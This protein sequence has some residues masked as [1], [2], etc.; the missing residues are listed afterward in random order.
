LDHFLK[1]VRSFSNRKGRNMS[2]ARFSYRPLSAGALLALAIVSVG[3]VWSAKA[4]QTRSQR[5]GLDGYCHV[6][7]PDA[8][9]WEKGSSEY[10]ATYDTAGTQA[11]NKSAQVNNRPAGAISQRAPNTPQYR[12]GQYEQSLPPVYYGAAGS[13]SQ[14]AGDHTYTGVRSFGTGGAGFRT[15]S[16]RQTAGG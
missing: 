7:I 5:I 14:T 4:D 3:A 6:W 13:W 1:F 16:G 10:K 8:Q 2:H 12:T 9:K 11:S 15:S